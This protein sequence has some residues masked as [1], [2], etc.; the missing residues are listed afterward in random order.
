MDNRARLRT[1]LIERS[2]RMGDFTLAS[3]VRSGYYVD[4]RRTTMSAEGQ[5]L[6][7][8]LGWA[9]VL[10]RLAHVTHVG[11]LTMGADPVAYAIA[12]RSW[13]ES[14]PVGAFSI[15]KRSKEHGLRQQIEGELPETAHCLVVEDATTTGGSVLE[16]VAAVRAHGAQV[17]AVLTL[18]DREEGAAVNLAAEGVCLLSLFTGQELLAAARQSAGGPA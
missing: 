18:V 12:H 17:E 15:R 7:G 8:K 4:V 13:L 6:V 11:G 1:L 14:R 9:V 10:E 5:F 16:A 3:G 2:L